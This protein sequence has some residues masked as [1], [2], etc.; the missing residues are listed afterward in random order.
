MLL[1]GSEP[2]ENRIS[3]CTFPQ[4]LENDQYDWYDNAVEIKQ[5]PGT[6]GGLWGKSG[7][8]PGIWQIVYSHNDYHELSDLSMI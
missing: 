7:G 1:L 2:E 6:I 4:I 8:L 5:G 3:V